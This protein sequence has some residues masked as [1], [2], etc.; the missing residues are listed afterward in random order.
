[1][2]NLQLTFFEMLWVVFCMIPMTV[3]LFLMIGIFPSFV[4]KFGALFG[5]AHLIVWIGLFQLLNWF[6]DGFKPYIRW[7][8]K[9]KLRKL[10]RN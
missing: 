2:K 7:L 10:R 1:M 8:T 4:S 5:F 9:R 3:T 6:T